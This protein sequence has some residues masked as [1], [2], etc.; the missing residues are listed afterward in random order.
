MSIT[1]LQKLFSQKQLAEHCIALLHLDY[2]QKHIHFQAI[3]YLQQGEPP[4]VC[5]I[6]DKV[7][8]SSY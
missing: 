1:T 7:Q 3:L 5:K 2:I 4:Y 8:Y 6:A